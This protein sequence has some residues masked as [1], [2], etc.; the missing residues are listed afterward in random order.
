MLDKGVYCIGLIE[1]VF[2]RN[3]ILKI[4]ESLFSKLDMDEKISLLR[5]TL[6]GQH[7]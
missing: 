1:E 6:E 2:E 4:P 7:S 5:S 3:L